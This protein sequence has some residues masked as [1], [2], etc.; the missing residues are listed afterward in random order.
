MLLLQGTLPIVVFW[1]GTLPI[2]VFGKGLY[3]LILPLARGG[4]RGF[5]TKAFNR[6]NQKIKRKTLRKNLP[7]AEIILWDRLKGRQLEGYKFRRQY[8]VEDFV[9]DFYCPE[10]KL[11]V[12][13]DGDSHYTEDALLS[14]RKRQIEIETF[15]IRFLRF[16]NREIYENVEGILLKIEERIKQITS[17][18]PPCKEGI[19]KGLLLVKGGEVSKNFPSTEGNRGTRTKV[20]SV[21]NWRIF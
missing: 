9:I 1:Q 5:I 13:V 4:R 12:E 18:T 14:D 15:G 19:K 11:A 3:Q 6:T 10:L 7:L 8:S 21:V 2:V 17:P 16:T 20:L